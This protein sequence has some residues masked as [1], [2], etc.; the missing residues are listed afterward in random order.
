MTRGMDSV[1]TETASG[2]HAHWKR[3]VK[4]K[5]MSVHENGKHSICHSGDV[6]QPQKLYMSI[7]TEG[8]LVQK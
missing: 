3:K 4:K 6:A 8:C 5:E 2:T 1:S 7:G